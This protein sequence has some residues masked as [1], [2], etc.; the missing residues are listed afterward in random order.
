MRGGGG[1]YYVEYGIYILCVTVAELMMSTVTTKYCFF[2]CINTICVHVCCQLFTWFN[3][4]TIVLSYDY[5]INYV[6]LYMYRLCPQ[7]E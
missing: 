5:N 7:K 2:E 1:A 6:T 4:D 3:D